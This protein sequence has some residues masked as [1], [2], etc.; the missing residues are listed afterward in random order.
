MGRWD[1]EQQRPL[2]SFVV[3]RRLAQA[4]REVGYLIDEEE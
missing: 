4:L 2:D 3:T 1:I